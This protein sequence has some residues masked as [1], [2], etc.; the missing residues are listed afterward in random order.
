MVVMTVVLMIMGDDG[1][2]GGGAARLN[3]LRHRQVQVCQF[4]PQG[5]KA[6]RRTELAGSLNNL[7]I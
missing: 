6:N 5:I 3:A 2:G 4:T 7:L 1:S